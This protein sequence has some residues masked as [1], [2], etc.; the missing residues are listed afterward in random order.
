MSPIIR[1]LHV[2]ERSQH[3]N[4]VIP[5]RNSKD[6]FVPTGIHAMT[7]L[8]SRSVR[9][10]NPNA[11]D[12]LSIPAILRAIRPAAKKAIRISSNLIVS[13]RYRA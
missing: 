13:R 11:F 2:M 3:R 8:T 10:K 5:I 1:F 6:V 12:R 4:R 9:S 7:A